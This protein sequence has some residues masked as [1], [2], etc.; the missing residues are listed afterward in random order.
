MA[1]SLLGKIRGA[2][3]FHRA[4]ACDMLQ[5]SYLWGGMYNMWGLCAHPVD[6]PHSPTFFLPAQLTLTG[7]LGQTG[8]YLVCR[9]GLLLWRVE[10][11]C[12]MVASHQHGLGHASWQDYTGVSGVM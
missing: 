2:V 9:L 7:T 10:H 6:A 4:I 1:G 5:W 12:G 11:R 3:H 8:R